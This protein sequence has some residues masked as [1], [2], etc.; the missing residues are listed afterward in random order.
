MTKLRN[1]SGDITTY[2]KE[3]KRI[4]RE[5]CEQLHANKLDNLDERDKFLET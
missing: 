1:E 5:Y 2:S 3:I 4:I